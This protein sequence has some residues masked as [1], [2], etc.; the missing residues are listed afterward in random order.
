[1]TELCP[2]SNAA[3]QEL[4]RLSLAS[5]IEV[6]DM[7][8]ILIPVL[9]AVVLG[10]TAFAQMSGMDHSQMNMGSQMGMADMMQMMGGMDKLTGKAFDR[11]FLSMMVP[12]HQA[13]V[14]MSKEILKTTRNAQVKAWANAIIK[15]QNTEIAQM[16]SWLKSYGGA[17]PKMAA[18]MNGMMT[19]MVS[20]IRKAAPANKDRAFVKG[21]LPHHG[22]AIMMANMALMQ[23]QNKN[24]LKLARNIAQ[25][26]AQEM[27]DYQ[28]FLLK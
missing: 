15:A 25:A 1:M 4:N 3:L 17:Y 12:H 23:S 19:G 26:Q 6:D 8:K 28:Q 21:M 18:S 9:T 16:N 2:T 14:D 5:F 24:I 20:D 13:A 11:A 10:T 22:S 7:K 27:Y